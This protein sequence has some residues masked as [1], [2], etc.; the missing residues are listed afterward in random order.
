MCHRVFFA[1]QT[2]VSV[3]FSRAIS[4]PF[5][6]RI[7]SLCL[8]PMS[9]LMQERDKAIE[10]FLA[11]LK[12]ESDKLGKSIH[13]D[14]MTA[15]GA[16]LNLLLSLK[17]NKNLPPKHVMGQITVTPYSW[18]EVSERRG[19]PSTA[20]A[21]INNFVPIPEFKVAA[22]ELA[23]RAQYNSSPAAYCIR[24]AVPTVDHVGIDEGI[25]DIEM[26]MFRI[27]APG[28]VE[29]VSFHGQQSSSCGTELRIWVRGKMRIGPV[30]ATQLIGLYEATPRFVPHY[31]PK[32]DD[33]YYR[34]Q[35][36][37]ENDRKNVSVVR[38]IMRWF[39]PAEIQQQWGVGL[40]VEGVDDAKERP[41]KIRKR[42][43]D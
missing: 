19:A 15:L 9:H 6:V 28:S 26:N 32:L 16:L 33:P 23:A 10:G 14:D 41:R 4:L 13:V 25:T 3:F 18:T 8:P 42:E 43:D 29:H 37:G 5:L 12:A 1:S 30:I 17:C 39:V 35:Q 36:E 40:H 20:S 2:V 21:T 34:Q 24:Y 11:A 7:I 38:K 22:Y 31:L 27:V